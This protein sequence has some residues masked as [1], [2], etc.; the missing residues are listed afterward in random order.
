MTDATTPVTPTAPTAPAAPK[1]T[2]PAPVGV[3]T[4]IEKDY[5]WV[6]AH[7][8]ALVL[9]LV[10]ILGTAAGAVYGVESLIAKH[11]L[12]AEQRADAKLTVIVAAANDSLQKSNAVNQQLLQMISQ[13]QAQNT[14]LAKSVA[15]RNAQNAQ[16]QKIDASLNAKDA[17]TRLS[18]QTQ[19]SPGEITVTG[20]D[21]VLDLPVTRRIIAD[22]DALVTT[23]ANLKDTTTQLA[24]ETA[25]FNKS[26]EAN[27]AQAKSIT[28]LQAQ[29]VG[30]AAACAAEVKTVKAQAR[31]SKWKYF[32]GGYIAGLATRGAI[33]VFT[34]V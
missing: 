32:L 21:V 13:L 29:N 3:V 24:N 2:T 34:G 11:D 23:T 5:T 8:L 18:A 26:Q 28:D 9:S 31:K 20:N 14:Q 10:L 30:Q 1:P 19:S 4:T 22:E 12:A 27:A 25:L 7:I 15:Q 16:Q 6:K 17:A 33:K